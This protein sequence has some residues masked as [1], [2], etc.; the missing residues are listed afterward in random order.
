MPPV[1][2]RKLSKA[3]GRKRSSHWKLESFQLVTCPDCGEA[4]L[5]HQVCPSCGKY[6]G[7]QVLEIKEK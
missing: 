1:P 3:R 2:K 7:V 4:V 6:R 5:P